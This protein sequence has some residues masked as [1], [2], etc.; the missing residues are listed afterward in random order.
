M[1]G[2]S[3]RAPQQQQRDPC[4]SPQPFF[5]PPCTISATSPALGALPSFT[6]RRSIFLSSAPGR[7]G[8]GVPFADCG[9]INI[10]PW[11][12]FNSPG[13]KCQRDSQLLAV[14]EML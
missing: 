7:D 3:P 8:L 6:P 13:L 9:F 10:S 2:V 14:F 4:V 12:G 11:L 1:L 5:C